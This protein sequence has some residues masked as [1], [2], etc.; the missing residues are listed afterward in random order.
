MAAEVSRVMSSAQAR[1]ELRDVAKAYGG[2]QALGGVS[3]S[4]G[5]KV[6]HGVVGLN[7]AGKSTLVKVIA[8]EVRPD[9]GAVAVNGMTVEMDS[10]RDA[11]R[12]GIAVVHQET[13]LC[14]TLSPL[15]NVFLGREDSMAGLLRWRAMRREAAALLERFRLSRVANVPVGSLTVAEQQRT[16]IVRALWGSASLILLDEPNSALSAEETEALFEAAE[17]ARGDGASLILVSHRLEEVLRVVDFVTVL[18]DGEVAGTFGREK[19]DVATLAQLM[20]GKEER[21]APAR[22]KQRQ[23]GSEELPAVVQ[24]DRWTHRSKVF[25][26]ITFSVEAGEIFGVIGMEG[27][28]AREVVRS[29]YGLE[30]ARGTIR[31][32][33]LA[34]KIR[35]PHDALKAGIG[36]VAGDRQREGLLLIAS[37]GENIGAVKPGEWSTSSFRS[38]RKLKALAWRYMQR[39]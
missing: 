37:V 18:R 39:F 32:K 15:E 17:Q 34:R 1:L 33:G 22:L 10:P 31:V 16:E 2:T 27:S 7:G 30:R 12:A 23:K 3:L 28:G 5:E 11:R 35:N 8:G 24:I 6:I 21:A 9:S 20:V 14:P 25:R 19:V 38:S 13:T 26:D 36:F 29:L 4:V